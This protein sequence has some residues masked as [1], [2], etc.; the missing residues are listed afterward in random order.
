MT[1]EVRYTH[2]LGAFALDVDFT[3]ERK[4]VTA[5]FGPSGSGK[6]AT[7]NA[8]AGLMTP[9]TGEIRLD[10]VTLLDTSAGLSVPVHKRR[11]GYV[12]QDS[13]LF[14]HKQVRANILFGARRSPDPPSP[15]MVDDMIALLDLA[16]LLDRYPGNLSGGERQRVAIARALLSGPRMLLLDEP[17]ASLDG[18]RKNEVL[19]YLERLGDAADIPIVYVSHSID[20]VTALADRIVVLNRGTVAAQGEVADIMTRLDLFPLTGRF[21]A[22]A[23]VDATITA[24]D[25]EDHLS[26]VSFDDGR[27]WLP[28]IDE[29]PGT[30]VRFRIRARDVVLAL[31]EPGAISANNILQGTVREMRHDAGAY[32]DVQIACG[33]TLLLARITHRSRKRLGIEPGR[34]VYAVVK[35]IN[36]DRRGTAAPRRETVRPA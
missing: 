27:L 32:V 1:L 25:A 18:P 12:F 6:T 31:A 21:E 5:L 29:P 33:T 24:H 13:R 2:R 4:S 35:S 20:E 3:V 28:E 11:L 23:V 14:P 10:G 26:E 15:A 36:L 7:V 34:E 30:P 8:I 17:L 19:P 22:G 16:P 9:E